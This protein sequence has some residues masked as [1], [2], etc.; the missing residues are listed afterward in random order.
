VTIRLKVARGYHVNANPPASDLYLPLEITFHDT[1]F[2]EAGAA[3]YPKGKIWRLK[4]SDEDLLVYGGKVK[5]IVPLAIPKNAQPGE[6]ALHGTLD[7][8]ACDH[9]V[10]FMPRSQAV[11]VKVLV[12]R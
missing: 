3:R 6:Y 12:E 4:D 2:A 7:Y 10:C 1:S 8:Q 5:I 9:A 11:S